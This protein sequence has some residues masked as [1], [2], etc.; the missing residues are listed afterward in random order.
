MLKKKNKELENSKETKNNK[1]NDSEIEKHA[2]KGVL[3]PL[4]SGL[5]SS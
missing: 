1:M 5:S 3:R 2:L 4:F